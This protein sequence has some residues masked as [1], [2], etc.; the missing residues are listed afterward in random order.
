MAKLNF[1]NSVS[2]N[3]LRKM[4]PLVASELTVVIQSEPGCGKTSL[5]SMIAEDNG[6]LDEALQLAQGA[7]AKLPE[8]ADVNDTIGWIYYKKNMAPQAIAALKESVDRSPR[9]PLFHYHL[10]LAYVQRGDRARARASFE[11]ALRLGS[12]FPGADDARRQLGTL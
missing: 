11:E 8:S 6:N 3:E 2:I 12:S 1:V 9:N 7:R 10:G 5:L 4:I